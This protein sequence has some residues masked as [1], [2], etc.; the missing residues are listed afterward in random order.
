MDYLESLLNFQNI[1]FSAIESISVVQP[2]ANNCKLAALTQCVQDCAALYDLTLKAMFKLH[3]LISPEALTSSR[4][5]FNRLYLLLERFFLRA[6]SHTY[7]RDFLK[8][9]ILPSVS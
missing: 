9:P 1:V 7:I 6:N 3:T 5:Y 2:T 4:E 8:I